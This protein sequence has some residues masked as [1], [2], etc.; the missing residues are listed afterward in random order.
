MGAANFSK[1]IEHIRLPIIFAFGLMMCNRYVEL[2]V[3]W[4]ATAPSLRPTSERVIFHFS[5]MSPLARPW[6]RKRTVF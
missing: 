4:K 2:S 6:A 1:K 5:R 3:L